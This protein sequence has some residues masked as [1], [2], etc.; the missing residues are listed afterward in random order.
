M[1]A[2]QRDPLIK[3]E[4]A[5][6]E[7]APTK[8]LVAYV[9]RDDDPSKKRKVVNSVAIDDGSAGIEH[10]VAHTMEQFHRH[11][12]EAKLQGTECFRDFPKCL[13]G[14]TLRMW[15]QIVH[16]DPG[17]VE[18]DQTKYNFTDA[19]KH[20]MNKV[21][22]HND[23]R[24]TQLYWMSHKM[25][26]PKEMSPRDFYFRF[27]E[28]LSVSLKLGGHFQTPNEHEQKTMLFN[29]FPAS[30]RQR[31]Q[32]S[33]MTIEDSSMDDIVSYFHTLHEFEVRDGRL[34]SGD[35]RKRDDSDRPHISSKKQR[36]RDRRENCNHD[37]Y[38][39]GNGNNRR[40]SR[41]SEQC[42]IHAYSNHTW[43]E[44]RSNPDSD[45][46]QPRNGKYYRRDSERDSD[47]SDES[48][49]NSSSS[50]GRSDES[51]GNSHNSGEEDDDD[52]QASDNESR[53]SRRS[54][55]SSDRDEDYD[56]GYVDS[57]E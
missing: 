41:W 6:K 52:R 38:R 31:F 32:R 11:E 33:A 25:K 23:M 9:E 35:K 49:S 40:G 22:G 44:C 51:D 2:T 18:A 29:A 53:R 34:Y 42:H 21:C 43:G 3:I 30:Y 55:Y 37:G 45:N 57:S 26:K 39:N 8:E 27:Q 47:G 24:D 50:R 5:W 54:S 20:L 13:N 19:E 36:G 48:S 28:I 7:D 16:D 4:R 14:A 56:A 15:E 12:H 17:Y 46:L 1:S 10:L